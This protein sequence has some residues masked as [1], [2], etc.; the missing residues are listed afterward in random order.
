MPQSD[1]IRIAI[2]DDDQDD[3][4]IINDY[5]SDI[6]GKDFIVHWYKDYSTALQKIRERD[7]HLYFIDYRLG[8]QTG[9]DLL[10]EA[11]AMG[12]DEPIVLLT[13]NGNKAIDIMAME[14]GATDY[15]V[16]SELNTEKLERC[17]RYSLDRA[18]F[19][20]ELKAR[21]NKYRNLFENSKDAVFIADEH[22][23]FVEVNNSASL[24]L[25][26]AVNDLYS[27]SLNDFIK[28][29]TQKNRI[30][31]ILKNGKNTNDFEIRIHP[32]DEPVKVCLL[33]LSFHENENDE[34]VVHG[35]LH[36][37]TNIK[38]AE[39]SNLQSEKLAANERLVRMLAHEIRNPLNNIIL[40]TEH[41]L[42]RKEDDDVERNFLSI[43]QRNGSRINQII[44]E[45]LNLTKPPELVFDN[46]SL[47]EILNES[48]AV[49]HDRIELEK[50]VVEKIY[51]DE[52]LD[53]KADKPRLVM[54]ITNILINAIESMET[55]KGKLDVVLADAPEHFSVS[56]KDNGVGISEEYISKLFD[57]FFTLKKNGT[58]LG[59]AVSYSIIQSHRGAI[60]VDT[61]VGKGTNFII[62][63]K[64]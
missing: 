24:L 17:I 64:K 43:L 29:G 18:R 44:T 41:L 48:L 50:A 54:A 39:L 62:N 19:L 35:I 14:S 33:S 45:L 9:L 46:Y 47:Q 26:F 60:V 12:C 4:Y 30:S 56:I 5:I 1:K 55:G 11:T 58:G 42:L 53:I 28:E 23:R 34:M 3:Y 61:A 57:P 25:G 52:P 31:Q 59:L 20:K 37:I 27:R 2:V 8:S 32:R 38:K 6:D 63:F 22:L 10:H 40:T 7:Y 13:G 15:L 36:D 49:A 21:E 16:K 51:P